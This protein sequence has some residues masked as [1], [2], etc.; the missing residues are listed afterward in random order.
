MRSTWRV[1]RGILIFLGVGT[2][3]GASTAAAQT[4]ST[5]E[6]R[7]LGGY[8]GSMT[9]AGSGTGM[10]GPVIPY[11]GRFGGFMPYRMGGSGSLS[12]QSRGTSSMGSMR[13]S[14]SLTPMS[15]GMSSMGSSG[16]M[17]QGF[18]ARAP[19]FFRSPGA[20]GS[21]GGMGRM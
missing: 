3:A 11:A 20:I 14:F 5:G 7:S 21:S 6:G 13:T 1:A 18:G 10:S 9:G 8:G 17:S 15:G 16:G 4:A 12:F 19:S 2:T